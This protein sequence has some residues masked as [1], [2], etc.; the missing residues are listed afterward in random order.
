[1][2]VL[3]RVLFITVIFLEVLTFI[4]HFYLNKLEVTFTEFSNNI[5]KKYL[6]LI[7]DPRSVH[8]LPAQKC[9]DLAVIYRK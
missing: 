2:I 3:A 9:S 8:I 5:D 6:Y 1:M 4:Q 7:P